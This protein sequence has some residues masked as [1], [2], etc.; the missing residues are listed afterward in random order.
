MERSDATLL[1]VSDGVATITLNRPEAKNTLG[2]ELLAGLVGDLRRCIDDDAV[3]VIV[4]TNAGNTFCA[5][6]DLKAGR[7]GVATDEDAPSLVDVFELISSSPT[8]VVG[9]I[10]GH[11][12]GGGVGLA[13]ACDISV[14]ADDALVGFTEVRI[15][16]APAVISV[17]CLPKLRRADALEL[18]LSGE[19]IAAARAVEVG[20]F[21]RVAPATELDAAVGEVVA[22]V[23]RGGPNALAAA[24][25]LVFRVPGMDTAE[26]FAW[27][28]ARS[29]ELFDAPEAQEGIAAFR[30]RRD[31]PWVPGHH[32]E[33]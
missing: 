6:A 7:P 17:V 32:S 22:K 15:G 11:V 20:L 27:T 14:I 24:K 31:A 3:R 19:R 25:E 1:D 26:A 2:A 33:S 18:F 16:V 23:V 30:E 5:G 10:A 4:L 12:T 29:Q 13:A 28:S 8:P 9:R 21:N